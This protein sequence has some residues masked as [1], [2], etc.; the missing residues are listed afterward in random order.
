MSSFSSRFATIL[1]WRLRLIVESI[2]DRQ[3]SILYLK[4]K[5]EILKLFLDANHSMIVHEGMP[6]WHRLLSRPLQSSVYFTL[7]HDFSATLLSRGF[8]T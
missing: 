1:L 2:D 7:G 6:A 4:K 8:R 3:M 5:L